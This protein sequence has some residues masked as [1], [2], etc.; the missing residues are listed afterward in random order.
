MR[1]PTSITMS[2]RLPSWK[3]S[4]IRP[5]SGTGSCSRPPALPAAAATKQKDRPSVPGPVFFRFRR[6]L[7]LGYPGWIELAQGAGLPRLQHPEG[8]L[9]FAGIG[10]AA[11]HLPGEAGI[12][13]V[14]AKALEM[15]H[16]HGAVLHL[17]HHDP[18]IF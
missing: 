4:L 3:T 13:Q 17:E 16:Q 7:H 12:F 5:K 14:R 2:R 10:I 15:V 9:A 1:S 11:G 18:A 6:E 8:A